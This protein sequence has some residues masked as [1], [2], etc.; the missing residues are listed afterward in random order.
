MRIGGMVGR[1]CRARPGYGSTRCRRRYTPAK[2][3]LLERRAVD[4]PSLRV[5]QHGLRVQQLHLEGPS[6][7]LAAHASS[8]VPVTVPSAFPT[9][10]PAALTATISILIR[11]STRRC[12]WISDSE[13]AAW[14]KSKSHGTDVNS[15][16][17]K[18]CRRE[19]AA[20]DVYYITTC[21][22]PFSF[23]REKRK[24][25]DRTRYYCY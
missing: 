18:T 4:L 15:P 5:V 14:N 1:C 21:T 16:C 17:K 12:R 25:K 24:E 6:P 20:A 11:R 2:Q 9:T 3:Q 19:L 7:L 13:A 22:F 10:Q 8:R 23:S